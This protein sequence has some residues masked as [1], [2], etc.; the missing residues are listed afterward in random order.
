[1]ANIFYIEKYDVQCQIALGL[2]LF[3]QRQKVESED[4][5]KP[6]KA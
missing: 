2:F 3:R 6:K 4:L 1:M 5:L